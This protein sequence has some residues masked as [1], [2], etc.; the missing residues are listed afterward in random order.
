MF[1]IFK[2]ED[3]RNEKLLDIKSQAKLEKVHSQ[4]QLKRD[5]LTLHYNH[6]VQKFIVD[7]LDK[8]IV[9]KNFQ[10]P[11]QNFT[12]RDSPQEGKMLG[13][14]RISSRTFKTQR[15]RIEDAM[16]ENELLYGDKLA[17]KFVDKT[18]L[19]NLRERQKEKEIVKEFKFKPKTSLDRVKETLLRN[20]FYLQLDNNQPIIR[21]DSVR[22][23]GG[24]ASGTHRVMSQSQKNNLLL[25]MDTMSSDGGKSSNSSKLRSQH[26]SMLNYG[27][28]RTNRNY[29]FKQ[30]LR[31][32]DNTKFKDLG[33][34]KSEIR[35]DSDNYKK[36]SH[37]KSLSKLENFVFDTEIKPKDLRPDLH[38]KSYF[39]G[40][41]QLAIKPQLSREYQQY[42]R[43]KIHEVNYD[44][45]RLLISPAFLKGSH[46]SRDH[47]QNQ[48]NMPNIF[49]Q[50]N[51]T[52]QK[53]QEKLNSLHILQ[54]FSNLSV[55]T[56]NLSSMNQ[57]V[58]F[59]EE[60]N[61]NR[62]ITITSQSPREKTIKMPLNINA[63]SPGIHG[64]TTK[65][66]KEFAVKS[67]GQTKYAKEVLLMCNV[68]KKK[69]PRASIKSQGNTLQGFSQGY[70]SSIDFLKKGDGKLSSNIDQ[71]NL[72]VYERI[73]QDY[74]H[75]K[76]HHL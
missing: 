13:Q 75:T 58:Q 61:K 30:K 15:Q 37:R 64:V 42:T 43:D 50:S 20:Q 32:I 14:F 24:G 53:E 55:Q 66:E 48:N 63:N 17:E 65:E 21:T 41:Q 11:S 72:E 69:D 16:Q 10:P 1:N 45:Q 35:E 34:D 7:M 59:I 44:N 25:K 74:E 67:Q 28:G 4:Q 33:N 36:Q 29:L 18:K 5:E 70:R 60:A 31:H 47:H 49:N 56:K 71:N 3:T 6:R 2:F 76:R 19:Q 26:E 57:N 68:M 12:H 22:N 73:K 40:T 54:S 23:R 62:K 9:V 38:V 39:K 46:T 8:P 27:S 51:K 52:T